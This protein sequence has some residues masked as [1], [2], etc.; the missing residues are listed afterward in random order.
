[1]CYRKAK[2][3]KAKSTLKEK[4]SRKPKAKERVTLKVREKVMLLKKKVKGNPKEK[5]KKQ[6]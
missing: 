4:S 1:M 5:T 2:E 3:A 6:T